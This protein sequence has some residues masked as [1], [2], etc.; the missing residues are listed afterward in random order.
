MKSLSNPCLIKLLRENYNVKKICQILTHW[1]DM[2]K[3]FDFFNIFFIMLKFLEKINILENYER[4]YTS[5]IAFKYRIK[6]KYL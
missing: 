6:C 5:K 1:L 4:I 3:I 2:L